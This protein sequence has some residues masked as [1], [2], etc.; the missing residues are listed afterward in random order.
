MIRPKCLL[1]FL[2]P[3]FSTATARA[4]DSGQRGTETDFEFGASVGWQWLDQNYGAPPIC[5]SERA[6]W[7]ASGPQL[8]VRSA[9]TPWPWLAA[10][11]EIG[12]GSFQRRRENLEGDTHVDLVNVSAAPF[13]DFKLLRR[14]IGVTLGIFGGITLL[15]GYFEKIDNNTSRNVSQLFYPFGL[16]AAANWPLS[17]DLSVGVNVSSELLWLSLFRHELGMHVEWTW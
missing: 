15:H 16:R 5:C 14:P 9:Y 3:L 11:A 2:V 10:G 1:V 7:T 12:V 17:S 6:V 8:D 4:E 13:V